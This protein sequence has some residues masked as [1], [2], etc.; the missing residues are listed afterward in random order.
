MSSAPS[1]SH[2][3][4][5]IGAINLPFPGKWV[6]NVLPCFTHIKLGNHGFWPQSFGGVLSDSVAI[7]SGAI[8]G[9]WA[10]DGS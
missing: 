7:T 1:P 4:K 9:H 6:V 8:D 2:H 5:Y 3:H 10:S